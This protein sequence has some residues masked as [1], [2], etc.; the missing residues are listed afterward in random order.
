ME[1]FIFSKS[2]GDKLS[3]LK[4]VTVMEAFGDHTDDAWIFNSCCYSLLVIYLLVDVVLGD[5]CAR[6]DVHL[7]FHCFG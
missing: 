3:K 2:W 1:L 6:G 4:A 5:M 7:Y